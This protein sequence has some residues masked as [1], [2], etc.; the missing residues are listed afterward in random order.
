VTYISVKNWRRFQHYDPT[1]RTPPWIKNY[2]ELMSDD[3][4]LELSMHRR[5]LLH[6]LWMEYASSRCRLTANTATLSRRLGGKVTS[7][8]LQAL[9]DAGFID[10]VASSVLAEG[11]Q[12]ASAALASRAPARS[13]ETETE[14]EQPRTDTETERLPKT[15]DLGL[16][17]G[18]GLERLADDPDFNREIDR[19]AELAEAARTT[20]DDIPF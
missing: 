3:A 8:D 17:S 5:G 1:K 6:A 10:L 19:L 11:Y 12:D 9:T 20:D 13:L 14:E 4:Y 15:S 16:G 7:R 18:N 2:T